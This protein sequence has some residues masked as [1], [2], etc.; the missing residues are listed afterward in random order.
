MSLVVMVLG[1]VECKKVVVMIWFVRFKLIMLMLFMLI[2][3][4][5]M[6]VLIVVSI[7]CQEL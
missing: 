7:W 3:V 6:L 2:L 1:R 4:V 5:V